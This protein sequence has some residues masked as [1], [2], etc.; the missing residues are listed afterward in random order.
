[1]IPAGLGCDPAGRPAGTRN[2]PPAERLACV[3]ARAPFAS[4]SLAF[5]R[6]KLAVGLRRT[7]ATLAT[8][9]SHSHK[10]PTRNETNGRSDAR[11]IIAGSPGD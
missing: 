1:V 10:V 4:R 3:R 5:G 6:P 2:H 8:Q 9:L 7:Q 11:S